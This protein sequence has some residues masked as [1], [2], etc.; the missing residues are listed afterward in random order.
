MGWT[1]WSFELDV[2]AERQDGKGKGGGANS[3]IFFDIVRE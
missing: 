1:S 2:G 3:W